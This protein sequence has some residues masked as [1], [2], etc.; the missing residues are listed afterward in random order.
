MPPEDPRITIQT[1]SGE[2]LVFDKAPERIVSLVPS[3]TETLIELGAGNRVVGITNY[4][5]HPARAVEFIPRLGGP[6]SISIDKIHALQPDLIIT[7][8]EENRETNIEPLRGK[9][10][11]FVTYVR[12]VEHAV[13]MVSDLGLLT[14][15]APKAAEIV[16]TIR[17]LVATADPSV[18][19]APLSTACFIWSDPWIAVGPDSYPG[20]LLEKFGFRNVFTREDGRYPE[21]DLDDI[22]E[23]GTDAILLLSERYA[24]GEPERKEIDTFFSANGRRPKVLIVDGSFLTWFGYRTIQGLRFL[25]QTKTKLLSETP[26]MP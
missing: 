7:D 6:K 5:I 1:D 16:D 22:A 20:D 9:Y 26:Q 25:R 2:S 15:T 4:C 8:K 12:T 24:F 14:R 3:I 11:M 17:Q 18:V 23:L 13:K 10:P 21:T 19:S